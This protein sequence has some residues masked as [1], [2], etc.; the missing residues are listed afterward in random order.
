MLGF[1]VDL[2]VIADSAGERL[3]A[4]TEQKYA[5]GQLQL[6]EQTFHMLQHFLMTL[7]RV[8]GL[9]DAHDFHFRELMQAIQSTHVLA[10][11]ACFTTE[12][13]CV[14]TV[15]DGQLALV[16]NHVAVDVRHRNL[17]SRDKVEVINLAMIHLAF[18]VG[19]LSCAVA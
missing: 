2:E 16:E 10:I 7:F 3:V 6:L 1:A 5:I 12:A 11:A 17:S 19:Q 8:F 15:L 18:L 14:G 13:L 9:V 4:A